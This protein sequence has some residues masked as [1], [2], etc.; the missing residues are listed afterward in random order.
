[1]PLICSEFL[2]V[3]MNLSSENVAF[4]EC[5]KENLSEKEKEE[6]IPPSKWR[7]QCYHTEVL[8][9]VHSKVIFSD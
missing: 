1:M 4:C 7:A 2:F 9:S 6:L 3:K 5:K 8:E